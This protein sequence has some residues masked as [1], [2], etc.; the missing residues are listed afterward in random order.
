MFDFHNSIRSVSKEEDEYMDG[1]WPDH[2]WKDWWPQPVRKEPKTRNTL[3]Y[4]AMGIIMSMQ[5][6]CNELPKPPPEVECPT[7]TQLLETIVFY[8]KIKM[9]RIVDINS[10]DELEIKL[11]RPITEKDCIRS[12]EWFL[13]EKNYQ[14]ALK[15]WKWDEMKETG[16]IPMKIPCLDNSDIPM[17]QKAIKE[18]ITQMIVEFYT[19]K[20]QASWSHNIQGNS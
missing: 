9:S 18:R 14:F 7:S 6:R 5:A 8:T 15:S 4:A 17:I 1:K 10:W 11:D 16:K 3:F 19:I 2:R 12:Y 20:Q 13:Q